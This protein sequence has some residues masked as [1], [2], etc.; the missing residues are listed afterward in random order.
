M[1]TI[2]WLVAVAAGCCTYVVRKALQVALNGALYQVWTVPPPP[3]PRIEMLPPLQEMWG[4]LITW[5]NQVSLSDWLMLLMLGAGAGMLLRLRCQRQE[6][7]LLQSGWLLIAMALIVL[8]IDYPPQLLRGIQDGVIAPAGFSLL[9]MLVLALNLVWVG[10]L[11]KIILILE[12]RIPEW[13]V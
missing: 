8:P 12:R 5:W 3:E 6:D 11:E 2:G 7:A 9:I 1:K 4:A 13:L 10:V